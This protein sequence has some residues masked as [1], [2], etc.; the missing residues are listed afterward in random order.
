M[1][2]RNASGRQVLK[3]RTKDRYANDYYDNHKF[4]VANLTDQWKPSE[5]TVV[6]VLS[7][8]VRPSCFCHYDFVLS[9]GSTEV[10]YRWFGEG[11]FCA[12]LSARRGLFAS[13]R[14]LP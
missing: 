6:L 4:G 7:I 3:G 1:W 10:L 12:R 8:F 5:R 2:K 14:L 13:L 11:L 9:G